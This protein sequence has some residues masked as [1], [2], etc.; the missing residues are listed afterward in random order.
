MRD[1]ER[2]WWITNQIQMKHEIKYF[3]NV[4]IEFAPLHPCS[5]SRNFLSGLTKRENWIRVRF[6]VEDCLV[7]F[8]AVS[9]IVILQQLLLQVTLV[10]EKL[11]K[12]VNILILI[13]P[14]LL[15]NSFLFLS[16]LFLDF[17]GTILTRTCLSKIFFT[18]IYC[19]P[20]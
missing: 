14:S 8:Q 4:V 6:H 2:Y 5:A 17:F 18:I 9:S 7:L 10:L 16:I 19:K 15:H 1:I 13:L 12:L 20:D 3:Q 11:G